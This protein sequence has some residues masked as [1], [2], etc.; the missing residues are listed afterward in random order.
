MDQSG[1]QSQESVA[2]FAFQWTERTV[3]DSPST[4][5]TRLFTEMRIWSDHLHGKVVAYVGSG[6]GRHVWALTELSGAREIISVELAQ[7]SIDHQRRTIHDPRVRFIQ[8]DAAQTTFLADFIYLTGVIQ[9]TA[10]PQ[11]TLR[12]CV[13]NLNDGGELVVSFYMVTPATMALEPIRFV[14]R[15]LP[16]RVLWAISPLLAPIFYAKRSVRTH[17]Y[18][19][20]VHT[21]Y[22]WFGSHAY[23]SYFSEDQVRR[24]FADAGI[25]ARN[26]QHLAKGLYKVRKGHLDP[27]S[28]EPVAFGA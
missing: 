10:D 5:Y 4:F 23:Q 7:A 24:M 16:K 26:V 20:A 14:T 9:H 1:T 19:N 3:W 22:D 21:A 25:D 15:R 17:G 13:E 11:K 12:R 18:K 2:S 6:N 28:N 27:L 8:G